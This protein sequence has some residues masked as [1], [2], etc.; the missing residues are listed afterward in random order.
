MKKKRKSMFLYYP[1]IYSK[2]VLY[3]FSFYAF[4]FFGLLTVSNIRKV[5]MDSSV[6]LTLRPY[7][8]RRLISF[9]FGTDVRQT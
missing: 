2:L 8:M 6:V 4:L 3:F 7:I 1:L 5:L 9:N